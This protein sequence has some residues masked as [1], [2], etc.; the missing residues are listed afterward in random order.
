MT[1]PRKVWLDRTTNE[2]VKSS[3][4]K[5]DA[6]SIKKGKVCPITGLEGLEGE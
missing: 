1:A 2:P 5:F 4:K 3:T 6:V